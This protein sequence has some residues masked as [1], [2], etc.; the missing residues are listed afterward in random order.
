[1]Y[2]IL[3]IGSHRSGTSIL[4]QS[5]QRMGLFLGWRHE[6]NSEA[7]F[8]LTLNEW[9]LRQAGTGWDRPTAIHDLIDDT[10]L[11]RLVRCYLVQRLKSLARY[12]YLGKRAFSGQTLFDVEGPWG[13]KDPRNTFTLPI[14]RSIYPNARAIHI[15]R[16]GVDVAA[17]LF[18]RR[19]RYLQRAERN[20]ERWGVLYHW[21]AR[22]EGFAQSV[23]CGNLRGAFDIWYEYEVEARRQVSNMGEMALSIRYEEF[24][25]DPP[26][27]LRRVSDFC[28]LT[29]SRDVIDSVGGDV[30]ASRA[31]VYRHSAALQSFA[32]EQSER[33]RILG[34]EA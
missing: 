27:V 15:S 24:L 14:W 8:F 5:I 6:D 23:R 12:Q 31:Q 28:G 32:L 33:L 26:T 13:W 3:I 29:V 18:S 30:D 25:R 21:V 22:R 1:M 10:R 34:Y 7:I 11:M 16:H 20:L 17:S 19:S 9:L 4:T 2:P